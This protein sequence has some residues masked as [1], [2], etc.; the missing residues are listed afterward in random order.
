[1]SA[2]HVQ[3]VTQVNV[4][5]R[6]DAEPP[7]H[8]FL[9]RRELNEVVWKSPKQIIR[10]HHLKPFELAISDHEMADKVAGDVLRARQRVRHVQGTVPILQYYLACRG[11]GLKRFV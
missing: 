7:R 3:G 11:C 2:V 8:D 1:M 9:Y 5:T 4:G 10:P 6:L